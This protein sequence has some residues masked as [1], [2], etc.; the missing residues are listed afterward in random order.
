[1]KYLFKGTV[2]WCKVKKPDEKYNN[3]TVDVIFDDESWE[4][5][6]ESGIQV[7]P[8]DS[9]HQQVAVGTPGSY[10]RFRRPH[11]KM[12]KGKIVEFGPPDVYIKKDDEYEKFDGLIGNGSEAEVIVSVYDTQ[13][14]KGHRWEK[15]AVTNLVEYGDND[16]DMPF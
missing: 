8:K 6:K 13:R 14:G 11:A 1:M 7:Q 3:Y 16:D 12:I 9:D 4:Q 5:F 2:N 15:I 10:V